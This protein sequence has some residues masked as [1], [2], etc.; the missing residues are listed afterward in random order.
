M[1]SKGFFFFFKPQKDF[2]LFQ[3]GRVMTKVQMGPEMELTNYPHPEFS[4]KKLF[5][6][7]VGLKSIWGLFYQKHFCALSQGCKQI[8]II[9]AIVSVVSRVVMMM[10]IKS[11]KVEVIAHC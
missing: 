9:E 7:K 6:L 8:K 11:N 5:L 10:L 4:P 3:K 1:Q 2:M